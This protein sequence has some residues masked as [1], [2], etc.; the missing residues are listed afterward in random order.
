VT[1]A[2]TKNRLTQDFS[3]ATELSNIVTAAASPH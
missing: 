1:F 3:A 2:V